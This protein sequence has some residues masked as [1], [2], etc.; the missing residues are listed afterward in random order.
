[1]RH[2][3]KRASSPKLIVWN[4]GLVNALTGDS[5][6]ANRRNYSWWGRLIENVVGAH[7]L[8]HLGGVPYSA[9]YWRHKNLQIDFVVKMAKGLWGIEVKSGNSKKP[10]GIPG[11]LSMYPVAHAMIIGSES[12]TLEMFFRSDPSELR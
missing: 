8:N 4:N 7:L 5:L 11:F 3:K 12:I 6:A 10:K 9:Y 2:A 1:M